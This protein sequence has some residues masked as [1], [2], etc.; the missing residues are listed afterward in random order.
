[1]EFYS[2][3][4]PKLDGTPRKLETDIRLCDSELTCIRMHCS[5]LCTLNL[6]NNRT[7]S[8]SHAALLASF[9]D[10]LLQAHL[11]DMYAKYNVREVV[12]RCTNSDPLLSLTPILRNH[13]VEIELTGAATSME[14]AQ[15]LWLHCTALKNLAY[16]KMHHSEI[17]VRD[18]FPRP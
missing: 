17:K 12:S 18:P 10:T 11:P 2:T 8:D 3:C 5:S 4:C 16:W 14:E 15:D 13:V 7:E 9:G 1:M 6:T